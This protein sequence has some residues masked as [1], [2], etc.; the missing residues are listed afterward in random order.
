MVQLASNKHYAL[1]DKD[2]WQTPPETV[3]DFAHAIGGFD[4][5][6]CAGADTSIGDL[7]NYRLEDDQDGLKLPWFGNVFINPP[8][9]Y[10]VEWLEKL[11]EELE[12]NRIDVAIMLTPDATDTKSWWH[13]Y[14]AENAK[15]ICFRFGRLD[16]VDPDDG[17]ENP[18][19]TFGTA[20]S[21]Y[22]DPPDEL[23]EVLAEK[24]HLVKTVESDEISKS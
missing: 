2:T 20:F 9:S 6:P 22:G 11:E 18:G 4:L 14:I 21:V 10:K 13:E 23:L 12:S 19:A 7:A 24:G 3:E 5:D 8:F 15:Y 16:Y 17:T 1:S